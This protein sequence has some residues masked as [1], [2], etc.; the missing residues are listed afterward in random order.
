MEDKIRSPRRRAPRKASEVNEK[1]EPFEPH[2]SEGC[3]GMDRQIVDRVTLA[4]SWNPNTTANGL[5]IAE[6]VFRAY[7]Q[8]KGA[9][10]FHWR[11]NSRSSAW[12][13]LPTAPHIY[14]I[15]DGTS[16]P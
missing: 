14:P 16:S 3:V 2:G 6:V 13:C 1:T 4:C 12:W 15:D 7:P 9:V 10:V 8:W 5:E 11:A